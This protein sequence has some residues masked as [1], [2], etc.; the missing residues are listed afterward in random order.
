MPS[1][2]RYLQAA[3]LGFVVVWGFLIFFENAYFSAPAFGLAPPIWTAWI[4]SFPL[5]VL[6]VIDTVAVFSIVALVVIGAVAKRRH[7]RSNTRGGV[8]STALAWLLILAAL[9]VVLYVV[10]GLTLPQLWNDLRSF[11]GH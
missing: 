11:V 5:W 3:L 2:E 9:A 1:W 6:D 8:G 4:A 10:F 7:Y